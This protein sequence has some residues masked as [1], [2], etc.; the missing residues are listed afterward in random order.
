MNV[1]SVDCYRAS[2]PLSPVNE[3]FSMKQGT[4]ASIAIVI[5]SLSAASVAF[6][7]CQSG[8]RDM[9]GTPARAEVC[10]VSAGMFKPNN[11]TASIIGV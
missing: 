10:I 1:R 2:A 6:A 9:E 8:T 5:L 7:E 3:G 4:Y 11:V